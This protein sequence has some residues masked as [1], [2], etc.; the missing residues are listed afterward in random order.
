MN[1]ETIAH[2]KNEAAEFKDLVAVVSLRVFVQEDK[3]LMPLIKA[4]S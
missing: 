4:V 3:M 2:P 1:V